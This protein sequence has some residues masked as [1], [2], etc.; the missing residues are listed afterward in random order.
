M[1][2]TVGEVLRAMAV[3]DRRA[4]IE[5]IL[6][7]RGVGRTAVVAVL[8]AAP[9]TDRVDVDLLVEEVKR[10]AAAELAEPGDASAYQAML[11]ADHDYF[12]A[13]QN[14]HQTAEEAPGGLLPPPGADRPMQAGARP[15]D[16]GEEPLDEELDGPLKKLRRRIR[17]Y[18]GRAHLNAAPP[19]PPA[20][21]RRA[22]IIGAGVAG[23]SRPYGCPDT[24]TDYDS[25]RNPSGR[26]PWL[27]AADA[28]DDA[29]QP[30]PM[31][32]KT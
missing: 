12:E 25:W 3:R 11:D 4:N 10:Q 5:A 9:A 26:P 21:P 31:R 23:D 14:A 24:V 1:T 6:D 16:D 13:N 29:A 7:L 18:R 8:K 2:I 20:K 15:V 27:T 30:K 32:A 17:R 28:D 19:T 22:F